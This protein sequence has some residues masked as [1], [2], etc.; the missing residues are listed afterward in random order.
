MHPNARYQDLTAGIS[1][2]RAS[3]DSQSAAIR[4][5]VEENFDRFVAVKNST[6]GTYLYMAIRLPLT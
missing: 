5:L 4:I 2:L 1:R 3:L 6:D